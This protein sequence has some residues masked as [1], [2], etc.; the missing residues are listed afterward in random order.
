MDTHSITQKVQT[1]KR[2]FKSL[3]AVAGLAFIGLGSLLTA[4][5]ANATVI[6]TPVTSGG[7]TCQRY[8]NEAYPGDG[9]FYYC[10]APSWE[11]SVGSPLYISAKRYSPGQ[12]PFGA[13][14][15]TNGLE[16]FLFENYTDFVNF[17]K[18]RNG[19]NNP[20]NPYPPAGVSG[21]TESFA[22]RNPTIITPGAPVIRP[23]IVLYRTKNGGISL[24]SGIPGNMD[25]EVGHFMNWWM[26]PL[27]GGPNHASQNPVQASKTPY[28]QLLEQD[29]ARL[30]RTGV[31]NLCQNV[32]VSDPRVCS[33]GQP[34]SQFVGKTPW[35]V[36]EMLNPYFFMPDPMATPP[37]DPWV[38]LWSE[39]ISAAGAQGTNNSRLRGDINNLLTCSKFYAGTVFQ[40]GPPATAANIPLAG[41]CTRPAP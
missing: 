4:S 25:H 14:M 7:V 38:E 15:L 41:G 34:L 29:K 22:D 40:N 13:T 35:Q 11:S 27:W 28:M 37:T 21:S 12:K 26:P 3:L 36:L 6:K 1:M 8:G 10:A 24:N 39:S 17:F 30:S 5:P 23:R 32:F 31:Y 19:S 16:I 20:G 18:Y 9:H 33:N 2:T